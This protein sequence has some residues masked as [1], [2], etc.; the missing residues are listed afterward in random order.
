MGWWGVRWNRAVRGRGD[1]GPLLFFVKKEGLRLMM[2]RYRIVS[3][4]FL[5]ILVLSAAVLPTSANTADSNNTY[6]HAFA[7]ALIGD[8]PRIGDKALEPDLEL[9]LELRDEINEDENIEFTIHTGD[10]KS[11]G[12]LCDDLNF[13]RWYELCNT[14][15]A[16]FMYVV[17]DNEWTDC[18]REKCGGY[19]PVKR[20]NKLREIFYST[21][22]SLGGYGISKMQQNLERQSDNPGDPGYEIFS[23]NFRWVYGDVMFVAL[24]VQGSNNNL[25]RTPEMDEEFYLRNSACNAFMRE[26]FNLAEENGNPGVMVI[27]QANPGFEATPEERT[28][29][30]DFLTVLLEETLDFNKPVVLV[31]GDTHYFRIDKPLINPSSKRRVINF[32]RVEMFGAPDVH[33]IRVTVDVN[34]PNLFSFK[35]GFVGPA[36]LEPDMSTTEL[37]ANVVPAISITVETSSLDFGMVGAGLSSA[38]SQIRIANT[39]TRDV[40]VTAGLGVDESGFYGGALKLNGGFVDGFSVGVP[41]DVTDFEHTEDVAASLEVP[42]W[43][44]GEYDGTVLFVAEGT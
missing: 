28:G 19:D 20:L 15:K 25:G 30:N 38:T 7:F 4:G 33:W 6:Q 37:S 14:F 22:E 1:L 31:H 26:S 17:G 2:M 3:I 40:V 13:S 29:F 39:G 35:Q 18:H 34:D 36:G 27:I 32:T 24:N 42:E 12:S 11:G 16:P 44:G 43:A 9:Y 8:I 5:A 41:A 23:E 21:P 10:F